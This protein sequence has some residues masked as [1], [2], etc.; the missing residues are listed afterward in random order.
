M[1]RSNVN[2]SQTVWWVERD[3]LLIAYYDAGIG[4]FINHTDTTK[5]I[6]ILYIQRPD[7]FLVPGETPERDGFVAGDTYLNTLL[8]NATP[9]LVTETTYLTQ[10]C[11]IPEQFHEVLIQ[12]VIA[13][14]YE[15]KIETLK[16]SMHFMSK[17]ENGVRKGR[18][19]SYKGRDG[20]KISITP[21]DF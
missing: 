19:Y 5:K 9:A 15:R 7:K 18:Q 14:G 17:Y 8:S 13:N 12:R 2:L 6:S 4:K 10:E 3:S 16:L 1:E 21:S 20:S 11:E